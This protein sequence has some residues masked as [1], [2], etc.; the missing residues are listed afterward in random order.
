MLET[1]LW[2]GLMSTRLD[3]L[4]FFFHVNPT[5]VWLLQQSIP[6]TP[7]YQINLK[8]YSINHLKLFLSNTGDK[9]IVLETLETKET[10]IFKN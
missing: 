3:F 6:N 1:L 8:V 5:T 2:D 7:R 10:S 4:G 9:S